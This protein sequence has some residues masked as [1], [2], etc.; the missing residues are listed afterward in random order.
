[1]AKLQVMHV[2]GPF[3]YHNPGN[4]VMPT[5]TLNKLM[6]TVVVVHKALQIGIAYQR[7]SKCDALHAWLSVCICLLLP[8]KWVMISAD[9]SLQAPCAHMHAYGMSKGEACY[10]EQHKQLAMCR[11][12]S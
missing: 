2:L 5:D 1:M 7:G 3:G 11:P 9:L 4:Q 12:T 10:N 6:L 8:A